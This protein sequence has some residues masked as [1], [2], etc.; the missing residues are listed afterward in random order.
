M[1]MREITIEEKDEINRVFEEVIKD[2]DL[3]F[4]PDV[5][6]I[7][8]NPEASESQRQEIVKKVNPE[9]I[10]RLISLASSAYMGNISRGKVA[11]FVKAI[12]R[13]GNIYVK[14]F[15]ICFSLLILAKDEK[16]KSILVEGFLA[17]AVGKLLAEQLGRAKES[18]QEIEIACLLMRVGTVL[19]YLHEKNSSEVLPEYFIARCHWAM[20]M[21]FV[22]KF[23][24]P[25][26]IGDI[27]YKI[28][29]QN[30]LDYGEKA[31]SNAGIIM[32]AFATIRHIVSLDGHLVVSSP[33]PEPGDELAFTPG[34]AISK[35][36]R[37]IGLSQYLEILKK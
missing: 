3:G 4:D 35:Y 27:V 13:L 8:D 28:F 34:N 25:E 5:L 37:S 26:I 15:V 17:A 1:S 19:M 22:E 31:I 2:I 36:M 29:G 30:C 21:K 12:E 16:S 14:V 10:A 33:M 7:L 32:M 6:K 23:E 18:I 20:T 11:T 24:L 9:I